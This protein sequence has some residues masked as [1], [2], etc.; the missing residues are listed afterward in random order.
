MDP[1]C[2]ALFGELDLLQECQ[3]MENNDL[4]IIQEI[5][6]AA[7][8]MGHLDI[9]TWASSHWSSFIW[10]NEATLYASKYGYSEIL[11]FAIKQGAPIHQNCLEE[12]AKN[13]HH[14]CVNI[15]LKCVSKTDGRILRCWDMLSAEA[16]DKLI[17][18]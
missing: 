16:Q 2:L 15:L 6:L 1:V 4:E 7:T 5:I 9:V 13:N 18:A 17:S 10:P 14:D 11:S 12:A 8:F 3:L